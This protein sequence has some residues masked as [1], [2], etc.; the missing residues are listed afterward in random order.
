MYTDGWK[1]NNCR[2]DGRKIPFAPGMAMFSRGSNGKTSLLDAVIFEPKEALTEWHKLVK[3]YTSRALTVPSDRVL[4]L[5]GIAEREHFP[6]MD[7]LQVCGGFLCF[8]NSSGP[9][10]NGSNGGQKSINRHLGH[11]CPSM[12]RSH[13]PGHT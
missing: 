1:V 13:L 6:L 7:T 5:S 10:T 4:A 2:Y 9:L 8:L 11:G 12:V 3:A